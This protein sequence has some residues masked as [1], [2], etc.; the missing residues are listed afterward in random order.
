MKS[1]LLSINLSPVPKPVIPEAVQIGN[2][3][4]N[5]LKYGSPIKAFEGDNLHSVR[6]VLLSNLTTVQ[7]TLRQN[8]AAGGVGG[9]NHEI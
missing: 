9:A 5:R 2:P 6:I 7:V 3:V 4:S 1:D 8:T